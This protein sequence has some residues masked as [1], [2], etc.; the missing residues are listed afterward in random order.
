M[1]ERIVEIILFLVNELRENKH[2]NDVDI[3]MLTRKGYTQT[4]ISSAFTWIFE[5]L[6]DGKYLVNEKVKN[7]SFRLLNENEKMIIDTDAYGYLIQCQQLGILNNHDVEKLI[8]RIILAGFSTVGLQKMKSFV[9]GYL[10]DAE[11][12]NGLISLDYNDTIH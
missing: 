8:E 9:A 2:L 1:Q 11:N 4:E 12:E 7:S 10:F 6:S 5:R 3:S